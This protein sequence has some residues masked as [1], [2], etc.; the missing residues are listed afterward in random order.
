[1]ADVSY[2]PKEVLQAK[3]YAAYVQGK[4]IGASKSIP[5]S[6]YNGAFDGNKF[7]EMMRLSS[8]AKDIFDI[9]SYQTVIKAVNECPQVSIIV[10]KRA[11]NHANGIT[12]LE[13]EDGKPFKGLKA[14][15]WN[16][17]VNRPH[18][19]MSRAEFVTIRDL[20]LFTHGY[21]FEYKEIPEG[22]GP[23]GM[24][25]RI[26]DPQYCEIT[27]KR[28]SLFYLNDHNELIDQ[29][30]YTENGIRTEIKDIENLFCYTNPNVTALNKG[31]LPESP[32]R[33]LK[34][35]INNSINNYKSR[36]RLIKKPFGALSG[37]GKDDVSAI[38][39]TEDE[40][41]DI[42]AAYRNNYGTEYEDQDD[43]IISPTELTF[44]PFMYPVKDMQL[45]E[46][47]K[48]DSAVIC[49]RLGYEYDLLA[50]DLG[51]VALNNKNEAGK[52]Q[53]QNHEIPHARN[54]D[55]QEMQS[56]KA[57][58]YG[59]KIKTSF[60][61]LPILQADRKMESETLRNNINALVIGFKNNQCNYDDMVMRVGIS[62]PNP[63]WKGKWWF[64]LTEEDKAHFDSSHNN[65]NNGT[66]QTNNGR[67]TG[68][69]QGQ[70]NDNQN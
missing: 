63:K 13:T 53:Y 46:L 60:D 25:R 55:E 26:L 28:R 9:T 5:T 30:F 27:W 16:R 69:N 66:N 70:G 52:N 14:A 61:H 36:N 67:D 22:F 62:K 21:C 23:E 45:L 54:I 48:S 6:A 44:T 49:D 17:V 1:M 32:L 64:E 18:T 15:D 8:L 19:L 50:R 68:D 11:A 58:V 40:R 20:F 43:L 3:V 31:F 42:Q 47:L 4:A 59:F 39:L 24:N 41:L 65:N 12:T 34:Y 33:T 35:P 10:F 7:R 2:I 51:G 38:P 29:F 56:L 37:K 57:S